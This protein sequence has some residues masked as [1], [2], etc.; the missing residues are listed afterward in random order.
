MME[1]VFAREVANFLCAS[2]CEDCAA[3]RVPV[4]EADL[5]QR[6]EIVDLLHNEEFWQLKFAV[7]CVVITGQAFL[8]FTIAKI[9]PL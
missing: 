1:S 8:N 5:E 9:N 6:G 3:A 4:T 2:F 7:L